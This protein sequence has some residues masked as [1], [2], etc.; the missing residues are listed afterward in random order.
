[1]RGLENLF[2]RFS[3]ITGAKYEQYDKESALLRFVTVCVKIFV[4]KLLGVQVWRLQKKSA[5][6]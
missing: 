4:N 1:M 3:H 2:V 5:F 6:V